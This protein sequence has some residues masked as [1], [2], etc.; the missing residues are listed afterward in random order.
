M[1]EKLLSYY[2]EKPPQVTLMEDYEINPYELH[3]YLYSYAVDDEK[4]Y[5]V[6]LE[7][8]LDTSED[9]DSVAVTVGRL[10]EHAGVTVLSWHVLNAAKATVGKEVLSSEE[11]GQN[12]DKLLLDLGPTDNNASVF[13]LAEVDLDFDPKV[14]KSPA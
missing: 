1:I 8:G 10:E 4:K 7:G 13:M 5:L 14:Y 3:Y 6:A 11:A 12:L 2:F 9:K